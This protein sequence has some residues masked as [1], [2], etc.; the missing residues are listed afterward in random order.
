MVVE[1][2]EAIVGDD[3]GEGDGDGIEAPG[4]DG[5]GIDAPVGARLGEDGEEEPLEDWLGEDGDELPPEDDWLGDEGGLGID[6][7]EEL[8][9]LRVDCCC[10]WTVLQ[11]VRA[12]SAA[13]HNI[14]VSRVMAASDAVPA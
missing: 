14:G 4:E 3:E 6:G 5:L 12:N 2:M 1:G 11:L 7:L 13:A 8:L 10:C 9:G